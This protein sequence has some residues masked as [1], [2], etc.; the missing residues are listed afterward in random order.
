MLGPPWMEYP[1]FGGQPTSA[2]WKLNG[3]PAVAVAAAAEIKLG[4][5]TPGSSTTVSGSMSVPA[6]F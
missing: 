6:L 4:W 5:L 3:V 2:T 1:P